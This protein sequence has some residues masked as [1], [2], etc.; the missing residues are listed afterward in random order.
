MAMEIHAS[1]VEQI[2]SPS[3]LSRR[4]RSASSP[5]GLYDFATQ[6]ATVT[7]Q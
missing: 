5:G 7:L 2:R 4:L 3:M 6:A 1:L